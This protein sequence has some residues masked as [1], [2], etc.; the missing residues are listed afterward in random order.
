MRSLFFMLVLTLAGCERTSPVAQH[1]QPQQQDGGDPCGGG[2][3]DVNADMHCDGCQ[4]NE[5]DGCC[6]DCSPLAPP[7]ECQIPCTEPD[8][9]P[10]EPSSVAGVCAD[11]AIGNCADS[12][13]DGKC[14]SAPAET[15][16]PTGSN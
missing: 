10:C 3:D 2:C 14:D 16:C 6:D 5:R 12:N 7:G 13:N 11:R 15:V 4:D 8:C 1:Q 9:Q